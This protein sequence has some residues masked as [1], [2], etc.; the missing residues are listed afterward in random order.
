MMA[1]SLDGGIDIIA[2]KVDRGTRIVVMEWEG[3]SST[4]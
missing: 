1:Q 3:G 2:I 4:N